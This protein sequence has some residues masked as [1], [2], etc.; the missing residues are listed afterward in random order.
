[1][2]AS[3]S[4]LVLGESNEI[5]NIGQLRERLLNGLLFI[6]SLPGSMLHVLFLISAGHNPF[7]GFSLVYT[8]LFAWL[9]VILFVQ[10]IPKWVR[11]G[12][13]IT[14][15]FIFGVINI[16]Q[17]GLNI[18]AWSIFLA[19]IGVAGLLLGTRVGLG[20]LLLSGI[21]LT[22]LRLLPTPG[23]V[24]Q[25]ISHYYQEPVDWLVAGFIILTLGILMLTF[26]ATLLRGLEAGTL[27]TR[28]LVEKLERSNTALQSS[29]LR[30]R[31]MVE[32]S[33]DIITI[34]SE[35]G[36]IEYI[37]PGTEQILGYK[38]EELIGKK[39]QDF[40]HPEEIELVVAAMS[41]GIPA[42]QTGNLELRLR[43]KD[44]SWRFMEAHGNE[45][46]KLPG[47]NVVIVNLRD[48]TERKAIEKDLQ[49][50]HRLREM[51]FASLNDAIFI[52]D[53]KTSIIKDCN[54]AACS[55]FGYSREELLGQTTAFLHTSPTALEEY[56]R[57]LFPAIDEKGFLN[58][59][60]F[61]MKRKD[62]TIFPTEHSVV[63]LD[64]P[65][66]GRVG[67]VSVV[68]DITGRKHL[69]QQ[70]QE[71][72]QGL[73]IQVSTKTREIQERQ[74]IQNAILEATDQSILMFDGRGIVKMANKI[75][76]TRM[77]LDLQDLLGVCVFDHFPP[78]IANSRRAVVNKVMKTGKA[79][80][81]QDERQ[82]IVF[83][84]HL[85][86]IYDYDGYI[87]LVVLYAR[88]ITN[89]KRTEIALQDSEE[90]YRTLAE[91]AQ[92]LIYIVDADDRILYV[93]SNAAR[94]LGRDPTQLI[95]E[96]Q[97]DFFP[98]EFAAGQLKSILETIR[99]GKPK[100]EERWSQFGSGPKTYIST[101]L[102]S[103]NIPSLGT[104][105][106]LGVTRD[107]TALKRTE[108]QLKRSYDQLE[109]RVAERTKELKDL[110]VEMRRLARKLITTQEEERRRISR[111][112]HDD[113]GQVL[114]TLKY[115]LAEMM[116]D[117]DAGH[118]ILPE[119]VADS[120][121]AVDEANK[122]IRAI[123]H[124]LRPP[125]LD[126]GGLDISLKDFCQDVSR[127]T[128]LKV[129]YN[130]IELNAIPDDIAVTLYRFTQEAFSNILKHAHATSVSVRLRYTQHKII[131]SISDN[132][133]GAL[134]PQEPAGIG[135]IGLRERIGFLGGEL[136]FQASPGKGM[137]IKAS[138]P[139]N[140]T[141]P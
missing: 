104:P 31:A 95:G 26:I 17:I 133:V 57:V 58:H 2:K 46:H 44:G 68:Q 28:S 37:N 99:S 72:R 112:L 86:P 38:N 124:T 126:A 100:Y 88:D 94:Q 91:A 24:Q 81:F 64:D 89:Q 21:T 19:W 56:R 116:N 125:L 77:N 128:R 27:N 97:S 109:Q 15:M 115:S 10:R 8:F 98:P 132:G 3:F 85:Y 5:T 60:E 92:D 30:F 80:S 1:M 122:S 141:H 84:N 11:A 22:I 103:L 6:I 20:T 4:R 134:E 25:T 59:F 78:E 35:D 41:P 139:W 62:G 49:E 53:A 48:I 111:E 107:I 74:Q 135:L 76:A 123:A 90:K 87:H 70:V 82:G 130:G 96:I 101:W 63:S 18:N 75:A 136:D 7:S 113:T 43:Q 69:E 127:R 79:I 138:I 102:V 23:P 67:W 16:F 108:E 34:L 106:V 33:T 93:N 52:L 32:E 9:L 83:D 29:E 13:L 131:V 47:E 119:K 51:L 42:S 71:A 12:S 54:E 66:A 40:L 118:R 14:S 50:S 65:T 55:I 114:V 137:L 36:T 140:P 117:L 39:V 61:R 120:I 73:E 105:A 129:D 121:K 45:M 110:S